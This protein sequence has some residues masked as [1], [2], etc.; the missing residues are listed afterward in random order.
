MKEIGGL[1]FRVLA[2]LTIAWASL[3][4][5]QALAE[6]PAGLQRCWSPDLLSGKPEEARRKPTQTSIDVVALKQETI[7]APTPVPPELRGSIRSVE[8]PGG[9]RLIALTFD[10]CETE[11]EIA[12]YEGRIVDVLRAENVRATFFASGKWMMT[13]PQR[14]EQLLADPLFE[15]GSHGWRHIDPLR[16]N[17]EQFGEELKLTEAAYGQRRR[18]LVIGPY[19]PSGFTLPPERMKLFRFPYGRC[20]AQGLTQ[21]ADAGFLSI[22]WDIVTGDPD[23]G[24]SAKAIAATILTNAHPG[25]IVVAHANGR[26]QHT[27]EAL[28]IAIPKLRAEDY[29]FVTVSE[30]IAAGKPVIA[31]AC[32]LNHKGDTAQ[33]SHTSR[34]GNSH[35][36]WS[37]FQRRN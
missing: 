1:V 10:L 8:L 18:G 23:P 5:A 34:R 36:F 7:P 17:Q 3:M 27:A 31:E 33:L 19:C 12:G 26:G 25:A 32:Y 16:A 20:N 28:E 35:D 30:L 14:A 2:R 4:G 24:R 29:S 37:V 21:A 22:Q 9:M 15:I 6:E 13:H 11:G